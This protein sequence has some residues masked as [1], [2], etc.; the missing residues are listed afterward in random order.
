MNNRIKKNMFLALSVIGAGVIVARAIDLASGDGR[1]WELL[2]AVLLYGMCF[3][4]YLDY[5]RA[6]RDGGSNRT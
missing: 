4:F 2:S 1:W 3:K 5:R 6:Y